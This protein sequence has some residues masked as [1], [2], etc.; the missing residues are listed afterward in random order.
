MSKTLSDAYLY[1]KAEGGLKFLWR[2][3]FP[4]KIEWINYVKIKHA[5]SGS[6]VPRLYRSRILH[7]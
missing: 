1:L 7:C 5:L 3:S 6:G 4:K 2:K